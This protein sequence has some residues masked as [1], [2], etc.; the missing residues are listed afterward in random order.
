MRGK[1]PCFI[2]DRALRPF[3]L[4]VERK[5]PRA[6]G[7]LTAATGE[8]LLQVVD[9]DQADAGAGGLPGQDRGERARG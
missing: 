1:H 8:Q 3:P 5:N 7:I 9:L 2:A 6:G 4:E